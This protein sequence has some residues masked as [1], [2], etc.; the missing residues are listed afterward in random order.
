MSLRCCMRR[1]R[2][3]S[4]MHP[5][6]LGYHQKHY[7]QEKKNY[8]IQ[9]PYNQ[10]VSTN[11]TKIFLKLFDKHFPC[12]HQLHKVFNRNTTKVS[13][14]CMSNLQQLVKKHNNFIQNN[15]NKTTIS[16]NCRDK[17]G[18][19]LNGKCRTE[20][21]VYKCT[22]LTKNNVKKVYFGVTELEFKKNR[23]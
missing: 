20:N 21:V 22:S 1:L 6:W 11:I 16:C 5:C 18:C 14:S 17:I 7:Q 19:P 23:Y 15:K 4:E 13:Y 8:L 2:D 3:G 12:T 9:P 10:N